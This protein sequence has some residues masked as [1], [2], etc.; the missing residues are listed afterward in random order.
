M[1]SLYP[2]GSLQ[3][4]LCSSSLKGFSDI[5]QDSEIR[6][7]L[8]KVPCGMVDFPTVSGLPIGLPA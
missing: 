3:N 1:L 2:M 4:P 7:V 8:G 6:M 5:L